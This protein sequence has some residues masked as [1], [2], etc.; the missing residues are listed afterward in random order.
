VGVADV[1]AADVGVA[2]VGAADVGVVD[3]SAADVGVADV[4]AVSPPAAFPACL[5]IG[6]FVVVVADTVTLANFELAVESTTASTTG[7]TGAGGVTGTTGTAG[8]VVV[9]TFGAAV[10]TGGS[11]AA[12]PYPLG[13]GGVTG[14]CCCCPVPLQWSH[15][16]VL[17]RDPYGPGGPGKPGGPSAPLKNCGYFENTIFFYRSPC[18]PGAPFGP[19]TPGAPS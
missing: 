13:V 5:T 9:A 1:G 16:P 10:G 18:G 12:L 2:D 11:G 19:R 14:F 6:A 8:F 3:V 17:P 15:E 7:A 4:G